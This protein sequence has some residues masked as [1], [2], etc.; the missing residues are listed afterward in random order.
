MLSEERF[1]V[2]LQLLQEKKA[3]T[4]TELTRILDTSESTIRR[5]LNTLAGMGKINKVHSV[6]GGWKHDLYGNL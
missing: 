6:T 5:D 4:V 1:Q 2:I 3:V